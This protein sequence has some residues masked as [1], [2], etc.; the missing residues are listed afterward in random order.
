MYLDTG[1]AKSGLEHIWLGHQNNFRRLAH[2]NS[3]N[4]LQNF[5]HRLMSIGQY[6]AYA[7]RKIPAE[8][9]GGFQVIYEVDGG[10]Y[11]SVIIA[12]NGYIVTA[13]IANDATK[14]R[15]YNGPN[16]KYDFHG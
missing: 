16:F 5:I 15:L 2:V 7:Y 8:R 3:A 13:T 1:D 14:K 6:S 9:G 11:L 4:E 10:V 12:R